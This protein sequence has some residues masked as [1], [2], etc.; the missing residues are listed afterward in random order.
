MNALAMLFRVLERWIVLPLALGL[1]VLPSLQYE[2]RAGRG[3]F[4]DTTFYG[5]PLPWNSR[6]IAFSL[7][8]DLYVLPLLIDI[9]II[10]GL[11]LIL[12]RR[13]IRLTKR[14]AALD[15]LVLLTVW[16]WGLASLVLL[17]P[18]QIF[19]WFPSAWYRDPWVE[20]HSVAFA[21]AF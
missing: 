18:V 20:I 1:F 9:A 12:A 14:P 13:R 7:T 5:A 2:V 21:P 6:G 15:H 10:A 19:E 8:K 11:A 17:L 16:F 4:F 3:D